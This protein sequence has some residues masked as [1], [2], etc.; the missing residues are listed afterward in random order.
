MIL[1]R[2]KSGDFF[3]P[4]K[5]IPLTAEKGLPLAAMLCNLLVPGGSFDLE[6]RIRDGD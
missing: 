3:K 5:N 2:W 6:T 1:E 4:V